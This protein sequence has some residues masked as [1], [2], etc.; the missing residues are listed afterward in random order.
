MKISSETK[1]EIDKI[2][3]EE[4]VEPWEAVKISIETYCEYDEAKGFLPEQVKMIE[5]PKFSIVH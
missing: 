4:G 2:A 1:E 5:Q 3:L